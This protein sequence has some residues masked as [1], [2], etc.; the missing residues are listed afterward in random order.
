MTDGSPIP[1]SRLAP[2]AVV[3]RE[4]LHRGFIRLEKVVADT[5]LRGRPVRLVREVHHHGDGAA[6]LAY[7]PARR[8][9]VLVRQVRAAATLAGGDGILLE[10]IAGL[11]DDGEDPADTV[12]REALEEA[13]VALAAVE[14]VGAPFSTPGTVTERVHLFLGAIDAAAPRD[15]GGGVETEHEEIEVVEVP[16]A[17]LADL[18]DRGALGDMKTLLLVE[19]LRRRRPDLFSD[20]PFTGP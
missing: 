1:P 9:A 7:D 15:G 10:A 11:V 12:R 17:V 6:V 20:A 14:P 19:T 16:L 13:G 2:L 4:V 8:L 3:S 5:V 18:A